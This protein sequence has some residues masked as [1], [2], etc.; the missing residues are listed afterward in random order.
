MQ[1]RNQLGIL[2]P[3]RNTELR[4]C[5]YMCS[6]CGAQ[7]ISD[8]TNDPTGIM[9]IDV[10][11]KDGYRYRHGGAGIGLLIAGLFIILIG[12]AAFANF[13]IWPLILI[14]IGIWILNMELRRNSRYRQTPP[15]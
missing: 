6:N 4:Y 9:S 2:Y 14:L 15:P 1:K 12:V 8:Q 5:N 13:N 3:M 11:M 7:I 10:A